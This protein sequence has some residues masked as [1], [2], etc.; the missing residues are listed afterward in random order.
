[1]ARLWSA[2]GLARVARGLGASTV[3][4]GNCDWG[5]GCGWAC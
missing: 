2:E 4:A 5:C 1:V 3:T